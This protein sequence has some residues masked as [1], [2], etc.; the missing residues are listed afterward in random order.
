MIRNFI[1][2]RL[3]RTLIRLINKFG[4]FKKDQVQSFRLGKEFQLF[5]QFMF[6]LRRSN[7]I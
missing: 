4:D 6:H 7:F 3:D 1:I 5:P 2:K